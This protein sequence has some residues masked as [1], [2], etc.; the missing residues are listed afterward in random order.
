MKWRVDVASDRGLGN[1]GEDRILLEID[2]SVLKMLVGDLGT[3]IVQ[4]LLQAYVADV[5]TRLPQLREAL[6]AG[7]ADQLEKVAHT[8][9]GMASNLGISNV[10]EMSKDIVVAC[11]EKRDVDAF[12]AVP[13]LESAIEE[14][15]TYIATLDLSHFE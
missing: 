2:E 3:E 9:K 10:S 5:A 13:K 1:W 15:V 11:R 14:S 4:D 7:N 8:I 12:D 6:A